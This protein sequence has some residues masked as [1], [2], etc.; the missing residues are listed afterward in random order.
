MA[1]R[2]STA[3]PSAVYGGKAVKQFTSDLSNYAELRR[4]L[5]KDM[6][7]Q[8][9]SKTDLKASDTYAVD[10][11]IE[12]LN[13]WRSQSQASKT[14]RASRSG[15]APVERL[16][17]EALR[18]GYFAGSDKTVIAA[19]NIKLKTMTKEQAQLELMEDLNT[20][21]RTRNQDFYKAQGYIEDGVWDP[22][23]AS[24]D[25]LRSVVASGFIDQ[26]P[27]IAEATINEYIK[28]LGDAGAEQY[29]SERSSYANDI[30][31]IAKLILG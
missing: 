2:R 1:A 20:L 21:D 19:A 22:E 18:S 6:R 30:L 10:R 28:R 27:D 9:V 26:Y 31:A 8:T 15:S 5:S 23:E 14:A 12:E 25:M 16:F 29:A 7:S 13:R 3:R 4:G 17:R 11:Y 24:D